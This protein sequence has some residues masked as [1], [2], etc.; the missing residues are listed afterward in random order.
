MPIPRRRYRGPKSQDVNRSIGGGDSPTP[1]E[2]AGRLSQLP[3]KFEDRSVALRADDFTTREQVSGVLG[4]LLAECNANKAG[5][6]LIPWFC[7]ALPS[8]KSRRDYQRDLREFFGHMADIGTHPYEVTGDHVRLYK[9]ALVQAGKRPASIARALSVVRGTYEQ[10]G[11]KGL[12]P[13]N[14]VGDIQA[15]TAP[16]VEKNTT[17]MIGEEDACRMLH[18][19]DTETVIGCRDHALLFT[20]FK[21]A[22]RSSAIARARYAG[23]RKL[24]HRIR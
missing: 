4:G 18:A 11:K 21:T 9:E 20:Y 17:P 24:D 16:H 2:N 1:P 12:V 5:A 19:P 23:P 6:A 22:C 15:V 8:P 10:F 13:W 7:D 14:Q 3:V